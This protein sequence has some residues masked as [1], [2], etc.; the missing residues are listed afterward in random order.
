M[1]C[2][3]KEVRNH[4]VLAGAGTGKTTTIVG[5]VKYLLKS[6]TSKPEDILVLSFTNASAAEMSQRLTAELGVSVTASTF[7]KLGL[8]IITSA[9]GK[10]RKYTPQI[11]GSMYGSSWMC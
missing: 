6:G 2:I 11:S 5:Y 7:H 3:T 10:N 4:L 9:Q 8:D 1:R